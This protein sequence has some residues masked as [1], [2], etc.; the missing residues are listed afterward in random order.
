MKAKKPTATQLACLR[1][2]SAGESFFAHISRAIDRDDAEDRQ[3]Q[4]VHE[5]EPIQSQQ[6]SQKRRHGELERVE[7]ERRAAEYKRTPV[8]RKIV[9]ATGSEKLSSANPAPDCGDGDP[10][11]NADFHANNAFPKILITLHLI[12]RS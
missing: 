1:Q 4:H 7:P 9:F 6:F 10:G 5:Q 3:G 2:N 11:S 12:S 8:C